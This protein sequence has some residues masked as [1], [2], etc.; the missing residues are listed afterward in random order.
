MLGHCLLTANQFR[1]SLSP[2][3]AVESLSG[4]YTILRMMKTLFPFDRLTIKIR[5][6][7]T[8]EQS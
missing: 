8:V 2:K 5:Y 4:Y 7:T 1:A 6:K 3:G